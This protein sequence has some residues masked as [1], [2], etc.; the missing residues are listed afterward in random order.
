MQIRV[1]AVATC[2]CLGTTAHR[3][4]WRCLAI[5]HIFS[6]FFSAMAPQNSGSIAGMTVHLDNSL[7][8]PAAAPAPAL[9]ATAR[10]ASTREVF[11]L[12]SAAPVQAS[13]T[14]SAA[15]SSAAITNMAA[16]TAPAVAGA[17]VSIS[18]QGRQS[19]GPSG[20]AAMELLPSTLSSALARWPSS[21]V[22][23][24]LQRL[25]QT[26][27]QQATGG[28][29]GA[30]HRVLA[31]Q[32]WPAALVRVVDPES[33]ADAEHG[34][35]PLHTLLER[36]GLVQTPDGPRGVT[37]SLRVPL[38]WMRA[39]AQADAAKSGDGWVRTARATPASAPIASGS[40][41]GN[42][43]GNAGQRPLQV[44]FS[45]PSASL[46]SGA[47]ALALESPAFAGGRTSALM[48]L[49]FQPLLRS[50]A[51]TQAQALYS[52]HIAPHLRQDPWLQMTSLQVSGHLHHEEDAPHHASA[53][54]CD[55]PGCPYQGE[56]AC[57]QPFCMVLRA[58]APV[59]ALAHSSGAPSAHAP[60][61]R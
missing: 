6:P 60:G 21:G 10:T 34:L 37:V 3:P 58:P 49:E 33:A 38:A 42:G 57:V 4:L 47:L 56:T 15:A 40:G 2:R 8:A 13:A 27:V 36:Q 11:S 55:T 29:A 16:P 61:I 50:A 51:S 7:A 44:A 31:A 48:L 5:Q 20:T 12:T 45:G 23:R 43:N 17:L 25:V 39:L 35:E 24:P 53:A 52:H 54:L 14:S 26:L 59:E 22:G 9:G 18:A 32:H 41:N 19:L 28:G 46:Q 1:R 30:A